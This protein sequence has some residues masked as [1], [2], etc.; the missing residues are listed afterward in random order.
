MPPFKEVQ[1]SSIYHPSSTG[2]KEEKEGREKTNK[3]EHMNIQPPDNSMS[4]Y[5]TLVSVFLN[6]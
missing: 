3:K 1:G 5:F 2:K 6:V 4:E